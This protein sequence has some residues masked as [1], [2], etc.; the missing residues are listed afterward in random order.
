MIEL[1]NLGD[2][3]MVMIKIKYIPTEKEETAGIF[4]LTG[5]SQG[6]KGIYH[7]ACG[8]FYLR[9]LYGK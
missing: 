9:S 6:L 1:G 8:L 2:K 7:S 3:G 4:L 5:V